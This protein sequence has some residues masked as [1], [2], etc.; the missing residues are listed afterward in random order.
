MTVPERRRAERHAVNAP[1]TLFLAEGRQVRVQIADL[2]ELGALL[3]VADLE[4]PVLEGERA[5]LEHPE[6]GDGPPRG[7]TRRTPG[8]VVRVE[9]DFEP[10]GVVRRIA[11]F[12]DGGGAP[13]GSTIE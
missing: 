1:G 9:L 5:L 8:R 4:D 2:G 7:R 3:S 10:E 11:V 12:F 13:P 6:V